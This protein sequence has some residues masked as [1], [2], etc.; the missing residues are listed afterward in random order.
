MSHDVASLIPAFCSAFLK[1]S[2]F[3]SGGLAFPARIDVSAL[4]YTIESL[5]LLD[6]YLEAV[7]AGRALLPAQTYT[8]TVMAAGSYLGETI[9][10]NA[11]RKYEWTNYSDYFPNHPKLMNMI[12]EGLGSAAVLV[13]EKGA[14][15]MPINKIIRFIE[16]GPENNTHF[17]ASAE[18]R[19]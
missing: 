9:R 8:N 16:E 11:H 7:R 18:V 13:S 6:K 14:M 2:D 5:H 17:Y 15:T 4:D 1:E 19:E 3:E 10:R 12:S